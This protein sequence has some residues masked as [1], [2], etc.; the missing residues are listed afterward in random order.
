MSTPAAIDVNTMDLEALRK[1]ANEE[2]AKALEAP[3]AATDDQPRDDAGRFVA[4]QTAEVPAVEPA[5]EEND[6]L[7]PNDVIHNG[8][9]C[10]RL[11]TSG[12][13]VFYG[14]GPDIISRER[15]AYRQLRESK[16]HANNKIR[17]QNQQIKT[18]EAKSQAM[19][20]DERY[21]LQQR[22]QTEPDAVINEA[23][24]ARLANDPRIKAA[25]KVAKDRAV[26]EVTTAWVAEHPE[27]YA[28]PTNGKRMW[29]EMA[30]N[31]V[32]G[33]PT[34]QD[35]EAAYQS[36]K[37]DGLLQAKPDA[38]PQADVVAPVAAVARPAVR[39]SALPTRSTAV[40]APAAGPK[41]Y[42]EQELY[43]M[44]LDKLRELGGGGTN[45]W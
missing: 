20:A 36:L 41:Q 15:D 45:R 8:E 13:E 38:A 2:L 7:G 32:T 37:A 9:V 22:M 42:T 12:E 33:V 30:R 35:I 29:N 5:V 25:E 3:A 18:Y 43:D 4:Q 21:A 6:E 14:H 27:F 17:E 39:R 28:N 19:S 10:H 31:G 23:I 44:P 11:E 26:Q 24:E 40:N 16:V 34:P 1:L